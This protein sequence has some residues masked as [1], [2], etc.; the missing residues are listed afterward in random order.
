MTEPALQ[1][2]GVRGVASKLHDYHLQR[3]AIVYVRQSH[4]QQVVEHVE[5]TARQYALVDRAV[6][7]G[8]SRDRVVVIDEDQGQSGQ[9]MV[10]R[11]GFQ[12]VLAEVSLDHV[13]LILGLEMSR[14]AR[15]NKDWHQLLELCGVFRTLIADLDGVYDPAQYNDRLLLG[16]KGTLSEAELHV[17]KQRMYQ[18]RLSKARR[19]ELQFALRVAYVWSPTGESQYDPDEQVQQ[20]VRGICRK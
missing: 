17:L 2:R 1:P 3:L 19:G 12:R 6:A 9:S 7:L 13:G 5:S 10:T 16:L 14:L 18:G 8:W 15:S 11:L 20:D 4:P